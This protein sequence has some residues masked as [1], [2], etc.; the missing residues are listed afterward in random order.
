MIIQDHSG[1]PHT[2]LWLAPPLKIGCEQRQCGD[3]LRVVHTESASDLAQMASR[4]ST[5]LRVTLSYALSRLDA[6]HVC[7]SL[8]SSGRGWQQCHVGVGA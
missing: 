7:P 5:P 4:W 6:L 2:A 3:R 1:A 8:L